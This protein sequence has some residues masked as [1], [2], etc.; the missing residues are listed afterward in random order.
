MVDFLINDDAVRQ[1][2]PTFL[3]MVNNQDDDVL[4]LAHGYADPWILKELDIARWLD[5]NPERRIV[6]LLGIHFAGEAGYTNSNGGVVE[7]VVED[8]LKQ[9]V[10]PVNAQ[11]RILLYAV[12]HFHAKFA[13]TG[14][15]NKDPN[16][17]DAFSF[18]ETKPLMFHPTEVVLGSS[19]LTTAAM[20]G[21]NIE[22]D[23]HITRDCITELGQFASKMSTLLK[24]AIA[25]T[26]E[27]GTYSQTWTNELRGYL[28][29]RI[30]DLSKEHTF[31]ENRAMEAYSKSLERDLMDP[32]R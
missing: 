16:L 18:D 1:T 15:S 29:R 9:W 23:T 10:L 12:E 25:R 19:N 14:R 8:V 17:V 32:D 27:T 28:N 26:N 2:L 13:A 24:R 4:L 3:R 6:I 5:L 20:H 31:K 11:E 21:P 22:L 30:E 7:R